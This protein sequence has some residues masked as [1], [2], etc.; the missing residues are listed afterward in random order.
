MSKIKQITATEIFDAKGNPTL[1]V[2]VVLQDDSVGIASFPNGTSL[3]SFE[4]VSLHDR[5]Q[6]LFSGLTVQQAITNIHTTL[7]LALIGKEASHQADIDRTMIDLDGTQNKA[8]LGAN[9]ILSISMAVAKAAAKSAILPLFL[10]LRQFIHTD[11]ISLKVPIPMFTVINGGVLGNYNLNFQDFLIIPATSATYENSLKLGYTS[12]RAVKQEMIL[13]RFSIAT[14]EGGGYAPAL[15]S[16]LEA[17]EL[18]HKAVGTTPYRYGFDIFC[19]IDAAANAFSQNKTYHIKDK[20]MTLSANDMANYYDELNKKFHL[21]YLEDPLAEEN[22]DGW[23]A[24]TEKIG[25]E[26]MIV[27]DDLIS[28]NP[29]RL[30]TAL[31]KKAVTGVVVKPN[32]V[33]TVIEAL[34][35]VEVARLSGLKIIVSSRSGE[36]NDDF[37]ADFAVAVSA[38]YMKLGGLQRGEHI[39]KYNRLFVIDKQIHAMNGIMNG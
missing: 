10:Y 26:T 36:T 29:Y 21:L 3:S 35:L 24:L 32:Q 30:Q 20:S 25:S 17:M 22:W 2:M 34:A 16:N 11:N 12:Y 4:A 31:D 5:D 14:T 28:T 39:A 27:G 19:G 33:G 38:D 13:N 8:R 1:E 15:A 6:K 9:A 37:I 7:S 23:S 18:I